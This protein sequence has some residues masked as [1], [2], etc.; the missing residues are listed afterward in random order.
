MI[1]IKSEFS[2]EDVANANYESKQLF[3]IIGIILDVIAL[4][5]LVFFFYKVM[6]SDEYA[7]SL[8]LGMSAFIF[9]FVLIL[10]IDTRPNKFKK[11]LVKVNRAL[12]NGVNY[13]YQFN[14][15][16]VIIIEKFTNAESNNKIKYETFK[17]YKKTKSF[18]Y[19]YI[20]S[21][22]AFPIKLND[23]ENIEALENL[24]K[25]KINK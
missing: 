22:Q 5:L 9:V 15:E 2:L 24:L 6:T 7:W 12:E 10:L 18:I 1:E 8:S 14:D 19:L 20:T 13:T 25:V 17:K 16:D 23:I 11:R 21:L 4:G 3:K